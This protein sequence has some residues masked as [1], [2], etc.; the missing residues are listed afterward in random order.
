MQTPGESIAAIVLDLPPQ[1]WSSAQLLQ[2]LAKVEQAGYQRGIRA[3]H[4][5]QAAELH[6]SIRPAS[7]IS[8][9]RGPGS[10]EGQC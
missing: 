6:A 3:P 9:H 4:A 2:I 10:G 5:E 7:H 8:F 1:P